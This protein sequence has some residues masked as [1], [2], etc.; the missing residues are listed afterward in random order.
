M[1]TKKNKSTIEVT[2]LSPVSPEEKKSWLSV[3]FMQAGVMICVPSLLLGGI[4]AQ[5]M[6]LTT[7]I[8][9]GII[10]YLIVIVIFSLMG[11]MGSDLSV[12]TCITFLSGFGRN[13]TRY[14]VST[15]VFLSMIG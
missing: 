14:I 15:L 1:E 7:A 5:A 6:P 2:T 3:A 8:I 10:G 13:G 12:P 9:A 11:I 4:L